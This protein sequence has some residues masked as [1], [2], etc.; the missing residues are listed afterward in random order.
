MLHPLLITMNSKAD[1]MNTI[2]SKTKFLK[3]LLKANKISHKY[4]V[5]L[6]EI[7]V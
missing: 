4:Q 1:L 2:D 5:V 3:L 6:L 7:R